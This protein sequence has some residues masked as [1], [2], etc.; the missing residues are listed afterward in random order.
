MPPDMVGWLKG[1]QRFKNCQSSKAKATEQGLGR[2]GKSIKNTPETK[3]DNVQSFF[4]SKAIPAG[5]R[6]LDRGPARSHP[7]SLLAAEKNK[8]QIEKMESQL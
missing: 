8:Q 7:R 1:M 6:M 4:L 3:D 2:E 5:R